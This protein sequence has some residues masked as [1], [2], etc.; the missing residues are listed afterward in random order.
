MTLLEFLA[1]H[2]VVR[3]NQVEKLL[4][5]SLDA[6]RRRLNR[7]AV[8]GY[9]NRGTLYHRQPGHF[10]ISSAGLRAIGSRLPVPTLRAADYRHD[11]GLAWVWLAARSGAFGPLRGMVSERQMSSHDARAGAGA[12]EERFA[13]GRIG[14]TRHGGHLPDLLLHTASGH[15]VAVELELTHKTD[16]RLERILGAYA[17]DRRIDAVLYLVDDPRLARRIRTA[18]AR[19]G[20]EDLIHV[21]FTRWSER[22]G[23][24]EPVR[25]S[26]SR[27]A[28][29]QAER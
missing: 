26:G 3:A 28:T 12:G 14:H 5:V 2:R 11:I 24:P 9:V 1:E 15:T 13:V 19:V 17:V 16:R 6:A 8:D 22:V 20:A 10:L 4:G 23:P 18:A 27:A 29:A 7:L 25:S 21:Q